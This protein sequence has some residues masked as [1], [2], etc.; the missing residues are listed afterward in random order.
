MANIIPFLA[1]NRA[2]YTFSEDRYREPTEEEALELAE[3][4]DR[5]QRHLSTLRRGMLIEQCDLVNVEE[6]IGKVRQRCR[7]I[8]GSGGDI[9]R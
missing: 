6:K 8:V 7:D 1:E 4:L 9:M 5:I 2:E 3:C